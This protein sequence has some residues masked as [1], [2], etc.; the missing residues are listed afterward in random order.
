MPLSIL[1]LGPAPRYIAHSTPR[2]T[3]YAS[4]RDLLAALFRADLSCPCIVILQPRRAAAAAAVSK[5][6]SISLLHRALLPLDRLS[7]DQQILLLRHMFPL[8]N[9]LVV[10]HVSSFAHLKQL[11]V[12]QSPSSLLLH[13]TGISH[14][15]DDAFS[16]MIGRA[17][18]SATLA[19]AVADIVRLSFSMCSVSRLVPDRSYRAHLCALVGRWGFPAHEIS[20]DGLAFCVYVMLCYAAD[21]ARNHAPHARAAIPTNREILALVLVTRSSYIAQNP[22]H[23]FRHAADVLHACFYLLVRLGCL[24]MFRQWQLPLLDSTEPEHV[25]H[26]NGLVPKNN[27]T[28]NYNNENLGYSDGD[29]ND[30]DDDDDDENNEHSTNSMDGYQTM[31]I[32]ESLANG[33]T[34]TGPAPLL[35]AVQ[36]FALLVAALGHDI[37][38]PGVLNA[39]MTK[40]GVAAS[41]LYNDLHVLE[42]FHAL[43]FVNLI[44]R[45]CWPQFLDL[46]A[47]DLMEQC[48]VSDLIILSILATDM[49]V[50]FE[51]V[52]KL[53][54]LGP[55]GV[56]GARLMLALLLKCADISNVLRPLRVLA[57]W[58]L[59]LSREFDVMAA[60]EQRIADG[61]AATTEPDTG[62]PLLVPH[63]LPQVLVERAELHV[64]QLFF[65]DTFATGLFGS[66]AEVF[67]QLEFANTLLQQ[68]RVFWVQR[69][70]MGAG[71]GGL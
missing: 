10:G 8:P 49:A 71:Q 48:S 55:K 26:E 2:A 18:S 33:S 6:L 15:N 52:K 30:D 13:W 29:H 59:V 58:A 67:P 39:F 44:V 19:P 24:P 23:N 46:H 60:L 28:N 31:L 50:H 5:T 64:G 4:F 27:D 34:G 20:S 66:M 61:H 54:A 17:F 36:T 62:V 56:P 38:H 43:V 68:N 53:D 41:R 57:Q 22:F 1:L 51:Y 7:L 12:A 35:D 63:S 40:H 25:T 70:A 37:G 47:S 9:V 16:T 11:L 14:I 21:H 3:A 45:V 69:Q 32:P 42:L 65:I